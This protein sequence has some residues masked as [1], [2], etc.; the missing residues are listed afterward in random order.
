LIRRVGADGVPLLLAAECVGGADLF[1]ARRVVARRIL[2]LDK[3]VARERTAATGG[4][5][6]PALVGAVAVPLRLTAER[7]GA[8]HE[9]AAF[10][11]LAS[12]ILMGV[13]A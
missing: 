12:R 4:A 5:P 2:M 8:T 3:A 1:A 7:I 11:V 10:G 6:C 13:E 9:L